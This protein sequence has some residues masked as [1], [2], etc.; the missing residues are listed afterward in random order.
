VLLTVEKAVTAQSNKNNKQ[1][2]RM[3]HHHT[4]ITFHWSVTGRAG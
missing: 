2:G 1:F 4:A 3:Q